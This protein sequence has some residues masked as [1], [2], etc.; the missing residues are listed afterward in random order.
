MAIQVIP[1]P[2]DLP[3]YSFRVKLEGRDFTF[4]VQYSTRGDR[5]YLSIAD[6]DNTPLVSGLKLVSNWPLL[7]YY[8]SDP[9][10]PQGELFAM[11]TNS[12]I[13]PAGFG[14]LGLGQRVELTYFETADALEFRAARDG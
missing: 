3:Y 1:T 5:Y 2:T 9:R 10:V 14:E 6:S 4:S 12:D 7:E 13:T 11:S 8:Q